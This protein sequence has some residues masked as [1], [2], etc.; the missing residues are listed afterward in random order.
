MFYFY[1][2]VL[3]GPRFLYPVPWRSEVWSCLE[4]HLPL[5]LGCHCL[6][7]VGLS[8]RKTLLFPTSLFLFCLGL[9]RL[10]HTSDQ[11]LAPFVFATAENSLSL[12]LSSPPTD[13]QLA[14]PFERCQGRQGAAEACV[15][16][17]GMPDVW[18]AGK[19]LHRL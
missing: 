2:P 7:T 10:L 3:T 16:V 12:F 1:W 19:L 8:E 18:T 6:Q 17:C 9:P 4:Q 15:G 13:A 5:E 11:L 14:L